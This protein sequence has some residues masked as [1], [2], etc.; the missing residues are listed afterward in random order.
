MVHSC[1]YES[2]PDVEEGHAGNARGLPSATVLIKTAQERYPE[3]GSEV[4]A[5]FLGRLDDAI[6]NAKPRISIPRLLLESASGD[7]AATSSVGVQDF[8]AFVKSLKLPTIA[9]AITLLSG[10][11]LVI[12]HTNSDIGRA[13]YPYYA[14]TL[15][16]AA[17]V[18]DIRKRFMDSTTPAFEKLKNVKEDIER[19]VDSVADKGLNYLT[20]TEKAMNSALAPIKDKLALV[21]KFEAMLKKVNPDIDIPGNAIHCL[22]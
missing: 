2:I 13:M 10:L 20:I 18:P 12:M 6:E 16:F 19:K 8:V 17:S 22:V 7:A 3:A 15:T 4:E 11:L 21:T 9:F 5:E 1:E 14:C